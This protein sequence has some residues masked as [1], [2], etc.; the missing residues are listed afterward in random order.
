[1]KYIL[2]KMKCS[3]WTTKQKTLFIWSKKYEQIRGSTSKKNAFLADAL[4]VK[5]RCFLKL[6]KPKKCK[7]IFPYSFASENFKHFFILRKKILGAGI[8]P[9]PPN[10]RV[11]LGK[12][13]IK[14]SD[15]LVVRPLR[16]Y[17]P[18][19]NGLVVHAI[20][21]YK[22]LKR[23]LTIFLFL[24]NFWAITAGFYRKKVFFA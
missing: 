22:S 2:H 1:M 24:P 7:N 13:H 19:I 16:F 21:F 5:Y 12:T 17:P 6:E 4:H 15:F 8:Y 3:V 23:I 14:K 11:C 18:Y 20:F 10:G 9:P